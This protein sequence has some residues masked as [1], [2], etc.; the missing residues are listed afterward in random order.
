LAEEEKSELSQTQDEAGQSV[1]N[2]NLGKLTLILSLSLFVLILL[3]GSVA[4]GLFYYGK[5]QFEAPG[6][7]LANGQTETVYRLE[8]GKGVSQISAELESMGLIENGFIF[9]LGVRLSEADSKLKAGEYAIPAA[10]SMAEIMDI[11]R[12]GKSILY[13]L[14]VPEGLTSKQAMRLVAAHEILQGDMSDTDVPEEGAI[15]PE[16]YLFLRGTTRQEIIARMRQA[17]DEVLSEL[18]ANRAPDLPI[19]TPEDAV[20]LASIVEKETGLADERPLVAGVFVN[21][22]KKGMRLESDPT[23]IYGLTEGEPLGRGLR[24]SELKRVTPYNT[25]EI[26]GLPPTPIANPGREALA[27]VLNP[28]ETKALF[29][30]ADGTGG[31]AFA[32]TY[33]E[34][35]R[36]VAAWR[37]IEREQK[38][39]Q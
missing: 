25:Y 34:H 36:N 7:N 35:R 8:R 38:K 19:D 14:T 3:V 18:W 26:D 12:E 13:K 27:A 6:P 9:Q 1:A 22:L 23:I 37:R 29:F 15:L 4:S 24:Q 32:E 5:T 28:P 33:S 30:V 39:K 16:T 11:L 20:I 17:H 2:K 31:H 10:A 21:R